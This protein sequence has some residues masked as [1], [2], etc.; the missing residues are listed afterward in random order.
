MD[1]LFLQYI[2]KYQKFRAGELQ[3]TNGTPVEVLSTGEQNYDSGPDFFNIRIRINGT[4]WAGNAEVHFRSSDWRKH[5]HHLDHAFDNVILHLVQINDED[6]KTAHGQIL[7]VAVLAYDDSLYKQYKQ[8][9]ET[10]KFIPCHGKLSCVSNLIRR[11][12]LDRLTVERLEKRAAQFEIRFQKNQNCWDETFY[13]FT[14]R[15]FGCNINAGPFELLAGSIPIKYFSKQHDSRLQIEAMLFGQ[16][17]LLVNHT[18][19]DNYQR[20]LLNEYTFLR[21][22]YKLTPIPGHL[23]KNLRLRPANFPAV[24]IAQFA[25]LIYNCRNLFSEVLECHTMDDI[26]SLLAVTAS[27]YWDTHYGFGKPSHRIIKKLSHTTIDL[28]TINTIAPFMFYYGNKRNI[29]KYKN[30]ALWLLEHIKPEKNSIITRWKSAGTN[31]ANAAE[32]Q[33]LLHLTSEYCKSRRCLTCEFGCLVLNS[34]Y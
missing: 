4:I 34:S 29:Q 28:I 25:S 20:A 10:R 19:P 8:M 30:L 1:E 18:N 7:P 17:G 26:Y 33:A 13:Q 21:N 15:A 9:I 3:L 11:H 12:W 5:G 32:S 14:A 23:W 6:T 27:E 2:W 22:K 24:R 31:P 16:A